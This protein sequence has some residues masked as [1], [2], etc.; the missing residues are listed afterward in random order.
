[1]RRC[2]FQLIALYSQ[3]NVIGVVRAGVIPAAAEMQRT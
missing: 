1:M 2:L 3:R